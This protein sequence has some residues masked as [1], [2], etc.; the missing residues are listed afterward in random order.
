M[1]ANGQ[2]NQV[3]IFQSIREVRVSAA[4]L[5]VLAVGHGVLPRVVLDAQLVKGFLL[6]LGFLGLLALQLHLA[7]DLI[8]L[9]LTETVCHAVA[10][11]FHFL[12]FF[13]EVAAQLRLL[14]AHPFK[15]S[16]ERE[17]ETSDPL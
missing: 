11:R 17:A 1:R 3:L 12:V 10:V 15:V 5:Q 14:V 6:F 7:R 16:P 13:C 9:E 8:G 4:H 2:C